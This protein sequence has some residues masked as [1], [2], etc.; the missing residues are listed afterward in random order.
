MILYYIFLGLEVASC[1]VFLMYRLLLY[2][3]IFLAH[4]NIS[5]EPMYDCTELHILH[6]TTLLLH[7]RNPNYSRYRKFDSTYLILVS[8]Q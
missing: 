7:P 8:L 1:A 2:K 4:C 6:S 5:M 3:V